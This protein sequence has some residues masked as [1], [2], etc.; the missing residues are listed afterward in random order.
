MLELASDIC[1][2]TNS[3]KNGVIGANRHASCVNVVPYTA[4]DSGSCA[5]ARR[6][7]LRLTY[8]VDISLTNCISLRE[9]STTLYASM[10]L[11]VSAIHVCRRENSQRSSTC[12][13]L[14]VTGTNGVLLV[15]CNL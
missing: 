6:S 10:S 7:R 4:S 14:V 8:Q 11:V 5:F 9:A 3:A 15:V 1:W 12:L 2:W 13:G